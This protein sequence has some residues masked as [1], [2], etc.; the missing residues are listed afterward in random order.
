M[1]AD[2]RIVLRIQKAILVLYPAE[3]VELVRDSPSMLMKAL[4]RGKREAR[5]T[6]EGGR[7]NDER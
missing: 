1:Q 2:D 5:C 4:E 7:R 3:V 6:K